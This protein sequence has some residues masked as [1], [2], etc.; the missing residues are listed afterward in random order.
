MLRA[1]VILASWLVTSAIAYG[2]T[3]EKVP[4]ILPYP[5]SQ[6]VTRLECGLWMRGEIEEGDL[7]RLQGIGRFDG[8]ICLDSPGGSLDGAIEIG[9][10]LRQALIGTYIPAGAE[11]LSACAVVFMAGSHFQ[12]EAG[13]VP[14]RFL[15]VEG[16]LAIH[17][18]AL[19][20]AAPSDMMLS[21]QDALAAYDAALAGIAQM[22][23]MF[24]ARESAT[25]LPWFR[26]SMLATM[27]RTP[28]ST[29]EYVDTPHE[30]HRWG[31][32]IVDVA[33][34]VLLDELDL[35]GLRIGAIDHLAVAR[36]CRNTAN[37]RKDISGV[38]DET[39][40]LLVNPDK[41]PSGGTGLFW[42]VSSDGIEGLPCF[43]GTGGQDPDMVFELN[44][45]ILTEEGS[46]GSG[47]LGAF[48]TGEVIA[49]PT[50]PLSEVAQ[51]AR[52]SLTSG[53]LRRVCYIRTEGS[54]RGLTRC[55]VAVSPQLSG[56]SSS[57]TSHASWYTGGTTVFVQ[58][59]GQMQNP[60]LTFQALNPSQTATLNGVPAWAEL[61]RLEA[62]QM[63]WCMR[64]KGQVVEYCVS[65]APL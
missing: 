50:Q 7:E 13:P 32:K 8:L 41:P 11:C 63:E 21:A 53:T 54:V 51:L 17:A 2:A 45:D 9:S 43:V 26:S 4:L 24:E 37:W 60:D 40:L 15:S 35:G 1:C 34:P 19:D 33:G 46:I 42:S 12:H 27:L 47:G 36:A 18:P 55:D 30:V 25:A 56:D 44:T 31:I 58:P 29:F 28:N 39:S 62:G 23:N 5:Q 61:R 6:F 22:M 16:R 64:Q 48:L 65:D 49:P 10:Y 3:F 59:F 38:Q 57:V 14:H 20:I 52:E